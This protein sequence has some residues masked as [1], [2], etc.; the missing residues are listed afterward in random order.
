MTPE[1]LREVRIRACKHLV[2]MRER[3][4]ETG[5]PENYWSCADC[6]AV[7]K[8][9]LECLTRLS[10]VNQKEKSNANLGNN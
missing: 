6:P 8:M 5:Q 7:F 4:D 3:D 9:T 10:A 1:R 2:L